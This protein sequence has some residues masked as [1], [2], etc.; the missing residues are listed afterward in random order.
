MKS[1]TSKK[2]SGTPNF[3]NVMIKCSPQMRKYIMQ[4]N[5]GSVHVGLS[6][7][8]VLITSFYPSA[9]IAISFNHFAGECPDKDLP[10]TCGICAGRHETKDY[11][12]STLEKYVNCV[13][14]RERN[15]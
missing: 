9:N 15:F 10:A 7:C 14:I 4:D 1:W 11:N 2:L 8:K 13:Q 12:R 5:D 3:K 6:R